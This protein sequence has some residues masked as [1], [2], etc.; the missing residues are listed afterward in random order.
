MSNLIIR[1]SV[2]NEQ[3]KIGIISRSFRIF[4][5]ENFSSVENQLNTYVQRGDFHIVPMDSCVLLII[6][7]IVLSEDA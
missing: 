4:V 6:E 5:S 7:V 1:T 2:Q 3:F